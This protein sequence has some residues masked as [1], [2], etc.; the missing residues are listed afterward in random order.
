MRQTGDSEPMTCERVREA[1]SALVDGE[2]PG[3]DV[4]LVEA[5]VRSCPGCRAFRTSIEQLPR[6]GVVG[7][8]PQM[9]DLSRRVTKLSALADRAGTWSTVRLVL[10]VVAVQILV[11]SVPSLAARDEHGLAAHDS[12]HLGAFTVAYA[13]ALLV[14]AVRPAR[15]APCCR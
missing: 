1:I 13:V 10:A 6:V 12:R 8:A 14:V 15:R 5:H 7:V 9:P 2:D 4:R 3:V 11:F